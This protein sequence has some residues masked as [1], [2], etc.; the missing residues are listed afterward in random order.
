MSVTDITSTLL[1]KAEHDELS[2]FHLLHDIQ[3]GRPIAEKDRNRVVISITSS[4]DI[5]NRSP[6]KELAISQDIKAGITMIIKKPG[7]LVGCL[8]NYLRLMQANTVVICILNL[9]TDSE[10]LMAC[11]KL[12]AE[13]QE[14]YQDESYTLLFPLKPLTPHEMRRFTG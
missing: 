8:F 5:A 11:E 2:F 14:K 13:I 4:Q 9:P 12:I 3:A 1:R 7:N 6:D 10:T